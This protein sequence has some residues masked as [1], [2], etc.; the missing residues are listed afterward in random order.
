MARLLGDILRRFNLVGSRQS[1]VGSRGAFGALCHL[2]K[3]VARQRNPKPFTIH[4]SSFINKC[5]AQQS[6]PKLFTLHS[7]LL[8]KNIFTARS[9]KC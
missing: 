1:A 7:S 4:H 3:S 6:N 8:T 5:V 9:L 2:K